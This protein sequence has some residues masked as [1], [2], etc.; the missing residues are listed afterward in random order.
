MKFNFSGIQSKVE[1][2]W[3]LASGVQ[4]V[5]VNSFDLKNLPELPQRAEL[6]I[7]L[8]YPAYKI[9]KSGGTLDIFRYLETATDPQ[10][11]FQFITSP[12]VIGNAKDSYKHWQLSQ[13][14]L[15]HNCPHRT[16]LIPVWHWGADL[17]WLHQYLD[18]TQIVGVGA[19]VP[20][21]RMGKSRVESERA[22]AQKQLHILVGLC[23]KYPQRLE[24]YGINWTVALNAVKNTAWGGDSSIWLEGARYGWLIFCN[25][26]QVF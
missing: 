10:Y 4:Q 2:S 15:E 16:P 9:W 6:K 18:S 14:W 17:G 22:T 5:L 20:W 26:H 11:N 21:M 8:D 3:L 19:L 1:M 13:H 24:L 7:G 23:E 12:D 25:N